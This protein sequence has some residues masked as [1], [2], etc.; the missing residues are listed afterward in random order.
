MKHRTMITAHSGAENTADNTLESIR[1]LLNCG[2]DAIEVDVHRQGDVLVLNHDPVE[3]G[4]V[5]PLLAECFEIVA[6][7][8]RLKV[9]I[10][11]KEVGMVEA[12]YRLAQQY[13]ME[14]RLIYAGSENDD[15]LAFI[16]EHGLEVWYNDP[17]QATPGAPYCFHYGR[18]TDEMLAQSKAYAVWTVDDPLQIIRFLEAG[19]VNITTKIP[20]DACGLKIMLKL[21][22]ERW[23]DYPAPARLL[24]NLLNVLVENEAAKK[25]EITENMAVD[26]LL[27][28]WGPEDCG[29]VLYVSKKK[30]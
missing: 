5:Y 26:G 28:R 4:G 19:V 6:P 17:A 1:A 23:D 25:E 22:H 9:N 30:G 7:H 18:V 8:A 15:D 12:V 11:L 29:L 16:R 14:N 13:G 3:E 10:D 20:V 27:R 2:A 21:F 24:D